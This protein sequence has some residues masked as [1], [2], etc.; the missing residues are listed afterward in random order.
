MALVVYMKGKRILAISTGRIDVQNGHDRGDSRGRGGSR[1]GSNRNGDV[2]L[3]NGNRCVHNG[4]DPGLVPEL[5]YKLNRSSI[6]LTLL[7]DF[8]FCLCF[9][10]L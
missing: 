5:M 4:R 8:S 1:G 3:G 9:M 10:L 7:L 2:R 6:L